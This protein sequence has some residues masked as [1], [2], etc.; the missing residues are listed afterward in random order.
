[1]AGCTAAALR[2]RSG[3]AAA[4]PAGL[5]LALELLTGDAR[6][7]FPYAMACAGAAGWRWGWPGAAVSGSLF[8][9]LRAAAGASLAVLQTELLG[10]TL[11]LAAALAA[12]R[13]G[14][15]AA[16]AAASL[17]GVAALLL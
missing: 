7:L 4:L 16:A 11:C 9:L 3:A 12:R 13:A 6:L 10:T 8:L 2:G 1:M 5:W 17:A 14:P 15:A